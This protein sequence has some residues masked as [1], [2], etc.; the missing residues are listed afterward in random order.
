MMW[1]LCSCYYSK[2]DWVLNGGIPDVGDYRPHKFSSAVWE[3]L[4]EHRTDLEILLAKHGDRVGH[5]IARICF[6]MWKSIRPYLRTKWRTSSGR[7]W[8]RKIII[9]RLLLNGR[10]YPDETRFPLHDPNDNASTCLAD[11]VTLPPYKA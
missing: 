10:R 2:Y 9:E 11:G 4:V 8:D 1:C 5:P 6:K 3:A 7:D